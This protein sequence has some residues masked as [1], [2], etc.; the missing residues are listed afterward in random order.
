MKLIAYHQNCFDGQT[1]ALVAWKAS[2]KT[3]ATVAVNYSLHKASVST[4]IDH[5]A[6]AL[7]VGTDPQSCILYVLDFSFPLPML[8]ELGRVF[9]SVLVL[10]HHKTAE[11]DL[12]DADIPTFSYTTVEGHTKLVYKV[13]R[14]VTVNFCMQESGALMTWKHFFPNSTVPD[15]VRYVSDRDLWQFR[16]PKTKPFTAGLGMFRNL[17]LTE[18]EPLLEDPDSLIV[19]G[20][21]A[22]KIQESRVKSTLSNPAKLI[23]AR[24]GDDE[25]EVGVYNAP[26]DITSEMLSVYVNTK[27]NPPVGLTY[28]IGSDN[29]VYCSLRSTSAVDCSVIARMMGGGGHSQACGFTV[30]LEDWVQVLQTQVLT[31]PAT[32]VDAL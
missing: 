10:D 5:L 12:K 20:E 24:V 2:G 9:R 19:K 25:F 21:V 16:D 29:N 4:V 7:P 15:F 1:A 28:T 30:P 22:L 8:Q 17:T 32:L 23:T 3:A 6:Q 18:M 31:N 11:E 27:G 26:A 13:A 14:N